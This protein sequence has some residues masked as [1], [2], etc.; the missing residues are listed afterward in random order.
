MRIGFGERGRD[1]KEAGRQ[2]HR[3]GNVPASS[4]HDVRPSPAKNARAERQGDER[5]GQR[6]GE[7]E[8]WAAREAFDAI[9][10]DLEPSLEQRSRLEVRRERDGDAPRPQR[11]GDRERREDVPV[12]PAGGDE[13]P[14]LARAG[15]HD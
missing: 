1:P 15:R 10:V 6:P 11:F 12:G 5:E 8:S 7:S 14:E 2:H 3:A 4:E 13:T 9:D